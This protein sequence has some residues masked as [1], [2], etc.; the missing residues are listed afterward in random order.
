MRAS[1]RSQPNCRRPGDD[2]ALA[3]TAPNGSRWRWAAA[4][5]IWEQMSNQNRDHTCKCRT[6]GGANLVLA[7]HMWK[8]RL[9]LGGLTDRERVGL[10]DL[11]RG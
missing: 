8:R 11:L 6:S 9:T 2:A 4:Q 3:A 7:P 5:V 1:V 10:I